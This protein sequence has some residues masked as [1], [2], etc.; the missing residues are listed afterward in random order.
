MSESYYLRQAEGRL[1]YQQ[2][3]ALYSSGGRVRV[4]RDLD[5]SLV[6]ADGDMEATIY[7]CDVPMPRSVDDLRDLL[8][9]GR[10]ELFDSYGCRVALDDVLKG[11]EVARR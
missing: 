10:Y 5:A 1:M 11:K 4:S 3:E 9:G 8:A 2:V 6:D 7:D